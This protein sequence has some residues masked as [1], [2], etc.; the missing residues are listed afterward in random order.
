MP[1][2]TNP[3]LGC[4]EFDQGIVPIV[5]IGEIRNS[6]FKISYLDMEFIKV[7]GLKAGWFE[8]SDIGGKT[9]YIN[10]C[11]SSELTIDVSAFSKGLYIAKNNDRTRKFIVQ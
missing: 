1:I 3:D 7:N 6:A 10:N 11:N 8:I 4:F 2:G 5:N 9:V